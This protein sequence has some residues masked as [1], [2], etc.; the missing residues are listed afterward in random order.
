MRNGAIRA[1]AERARRS[2]GRTDRLVQNEAMFRQANERLEQ[3]VEENEFDGRVMGFL[4]ECADDGCLGHIELTAVEYDAAHLLS[5]S[6]IILPPW[7]SA[8]R[9]RGDR[10]RPGERGGKRQL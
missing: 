8:H 4:C 9:G 1:R 2:L 3:A 5:D 10:G 6:Y 7:P